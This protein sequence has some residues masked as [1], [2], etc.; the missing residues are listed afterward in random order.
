MTGQPGSGV[1]VLVGAVIVEDHV[2][3]LAQRYLPLDLV[4]KAQKLLMPVTLHVL[5]DDAAI[6]HI[7]RRKERGR[8]VAF[9][10]MGQ[11]LAAA[12]FQRQAGLG[13]LKCLNL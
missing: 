2:D 9:I 13:A 10:V 7:E 8:A 6:Q 5:A 12:L 1:R 11:G 3:F 4:E